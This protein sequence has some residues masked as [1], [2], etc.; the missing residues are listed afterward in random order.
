MSQVV[1]R[2]QTLATLL[3]WLGPWTSDRSVPSGV[4]RE[5]WVIREGQLHGHRAHRANKPPK[6]GEPSLLDAYV[7]TPPTPT[8]GTYLIAPG[9]HFLGPDDPRLDRF[10][11]VLA[12]TGFRVV[13]PFLPAY[14]DLHVSDSAPR[15]LELVARALLERLL[16][17]ERVTLFSISF[18]SWPALEV[19]ARLGDRVDG[20]ITF[21][22]YANFEAAVRFCVDGVMRGP[23]GDVKLA[24][25]PL[26]SPALFLNLLPF[27]EGLQGEN[28][29]ALE[30]AWREMTYRTWGKMELK[31]SGRL[32]PIAR[33]LAP[34]VPEPHRELF[35]VGC[36]VVPGALELVDDALRRARGPLAF[37]SPALALRRLKC[38]VVICHGRDDDVIPYSE[39][40]ALHR[41]LEPLVPTRLYLTGLYGHT[42]AGRP[43]PRDLLREAVTLLGIARTMASGGR[44]R[45]VIR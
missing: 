15:D 35:L 30:A 40:L 23:D 18:G 45:E 19:A 25:D 44:L 5:T 42:G 41:V 13:A 28:T 16:P 9:L 6:S 14:V 39:A 21:G 34:R 43:S 24:R 22:G 17:G 2:S 3:R 1:T 20:V 12:R 10:C 38:P 29:L 27:I 31:A 11:R 26:N 8:L 33:A 4:N 36:G 7:Y 32:D 37:A